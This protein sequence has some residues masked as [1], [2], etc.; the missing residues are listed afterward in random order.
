[1]AD[2]AA[3]DVTTM[4]G[5]YTGVAG[6]AFNIDTVLGLDNSATDKLVVQGSTSGTT[7]LNVTNAGGT[8]AQTIEGIQ[9]VQVDGASDGAFTMTAPVQ[10]GSYEYRLFKNG[11]STPTDGDWYLRSTLIPTCENTPSM[12]PVVVPTYI[13]RPAVAAY[14]NAP[15]ANA[16]AGFTLLSS[17]HQRMG[18]HNGLT[19]AGAQT[20]GRILGGTQSNDG[21]TRFEYDQTT[22]GLQ[23]GRDIVHTTAASGAQQRAGVTAQYAH[24]SVD[25]R[26]RVRPLVGLAADTGSMGSDVMGGRLLHA[27][28]CQWRLCRCG[29]SNQ[30]RAQSFHRQLCGSLNAKWLASG[31][32]GGSRANGGECCGLAV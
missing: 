14:V 19:T 20:W 8:G 25:A 1:M 22:V 10:A 11:V 30:S 31:F 15:V 17:L 16:D 7:A 23:F 29:R 28:G 26:D 5:N 3:D 12:C 4:T 27:C 32:V 2:G 6:S 18:K 24:S 9:V 21:H 13:Y